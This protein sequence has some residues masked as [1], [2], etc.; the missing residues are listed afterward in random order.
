MVVCSCVSCTNNYNWGCGGSLK[1]RLKVY[2]SSFF[3]PTMDLWGSLSNRYEIIFADYGKILPDSET[4]TSKNREVTFVFI[5]NRDISASR[6]EANEDALDL[7]LNELEAKSASYLEKKD[8]ELIFGFISDPWYNTISDAKRLSPESRDINK[9]KQRISQLAESLEKFF[10]IDFDVL[11]SKYSREEIFSDRNW[12]FA[13]TRLTHAGSQMIVD[14][15]DTLLTRKEIS[16]YKVLLLDCDNTLWGG[17]VGEDG[18]EGI[19]LGTDGKGTIFCDFQQVIKKLSD[20]GVLVCLLSK[21]EENVVWKVFDTHN[22]MIL[23]RKDIIASRINW[24]DKPVNA[25]EIAKELNLGLDSFVFWDDN[26]LERDLMR[27]SVPQICTIE[28][29]D[30]IELWPRFLAESSL[31]S[32]LYMTAEDL[33]RKE[34]YKTQ[35][36][37]NNDLNNHF[38]HSEFIS[39]LQLKVDFLAISEGNINRAEQLAMKTNQLNFT[40]KRH[41]KVE[42]NEMRDKCEDYVF[43]TSLDD[44]YGSHGLVGLVAFKELSQNVAYLDTFLMSCRVFGRKLELKM[45][46]ELIKRCR[47]NKFMFLLIE[48]V[49]TP[50]NSMCRAIIEEVGGKEIS[51]QNLLKLSPGLVINENSPKSLFYLKK[52]ID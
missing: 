26:P 7:F 24:K 49:E 23:S 52:L 10:W 4:S 51:L 8:N 25:L 37:F 32:N 33:L 20:S 38:N 29:P 48:Y 1:N 39:S 31:F 46:E 42:I 40:Q 11:K 44:V 18:I 13:R 22:S 27:K 47:S 28:P 41:S 34:S 19:D 14:A 12:Y 3:K 45:F 16:P 17:V 50:R 35:S 43:M 9:F 15:L 6:G 36:Q 21:N 5:C 2:S 30:S